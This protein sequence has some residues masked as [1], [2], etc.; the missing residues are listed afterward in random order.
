MSVVK[1][2]VLTIFCAPRWTPGSLH[3]VL[4]HALLL[5]RWPST[6]L[7]SPGELLLDSVSWEAQP[8]TIGNA[9]LCTLL[10]LHGP[11]TFSV[12]YHMA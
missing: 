12:V 5:P 2:H 11:D 7:S 4:S 8:A 10:T 6:P 3:I 9:M 1:Q